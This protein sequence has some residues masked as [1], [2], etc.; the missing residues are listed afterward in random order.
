M[1]AFGFFIAFFI[2]P[3]IFALLNSLKDSIH[4]IIYIVIYLVIRLISAL[5]PIKNDKKCDDLSIFEKIYYYTYGAREAIILIAFFKSISFMYDAEKLTNI[6][7][8]LSEVK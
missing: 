5:Y 6:T 3:I 7:Q 8:L 2:V 1:S 4:M